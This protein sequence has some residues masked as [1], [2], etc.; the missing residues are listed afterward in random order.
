MLPVSRRRAL[1][2]E[3]TEEFLILLIQNEGELFKNLH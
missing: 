3:V 2:T 1:T